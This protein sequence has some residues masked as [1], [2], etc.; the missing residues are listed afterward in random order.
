MLGAYGA[1]YEAQGRWVDAVAKYGEAS[2]VQGLAE[3][4]KAGIEKKAA[5][6]LAL[7]AATNTVSADLV[8]AVGGRSEYQVVLPDKP[9]AT[10][11]VCLRAASSP[12]KRTGLGAQ[13]N[14]RAPTSALSLRYAPPARFWYSFRHVEDPP[15]DEIRS[16]RPVSTGVCPYCPKSDFLSVHWHETHHSNESPW[17]PKEVPLNDERILVLDAD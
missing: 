9:I 12:S 17:K 13:P 6:L 10:E 1:A 7:L 15:L 4:Q 8:L 2:R 11:A 5:E 3:S 16:F 14:L